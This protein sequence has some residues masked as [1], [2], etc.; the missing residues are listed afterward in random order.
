M[1]IDFMCE[2]STGSPS[3]NEQLLAVDQRDMRLTNSMN[4]P[5]VFEAMA[6]GRPAR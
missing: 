2:H 6:S 3:G 5:L 4:S 1:G